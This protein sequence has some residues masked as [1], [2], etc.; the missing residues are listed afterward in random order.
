VLAAPEPTPEDAPRALVWL[1]DDSIL[2]GELG[3]RALAD[4]Y[5]VTVFR[6]GATMLEALSAD[7]K[8]DLLILDWH[9][10]NMAGLELCHFVR[11]T[12]DPGNLPILILTA[13]GGDDLAEAFAAGANDFVRKPYSQAEFDARV[14]ALLRNQRIHARLVEVEQRLRV[15]G[16]FRERFI[17]VLAH[18]L[19]QPLNTFLFAN[20]AIA[21]AVSTSKTA[22]SLL[23]MQSRTAHRMTRMVTEL[24]D[25]TRSRPETGMP[26]ERRPM[27]LEP[28]ARTIIEEMRVG[29]PSHSF[30]LNVRGPC[31]GC[32]DRDRLAQIC[33]NLIGNAIEHSSSPSS[34]IEVGVEERSQHVEL[35]VS[36]EGTPIPSSLLPELF[37]PFRR[38]RDA[39]H[40]NGGL[41][42]GL[43]I[44]QEIVRA[45][46][47]TVS[48]ESN[49]RATVFRV[50]LPI[51]PAS[52]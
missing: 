13:T 3:R 20:H 50:S 1:V 35:A 7:G 31:K 43:Y 5:D 9:M 24:L 52:V 39:T 8:P 47:G 17:G 32:W 29:H 41:G 21:P 49:V 18:D 26:I 46:G 34:P 40:A 15:E 45:H 12:R 11:E 2:Q 23:A 30:R 10:P 27:D 33:S 36:N 14:A 37:E 51:G 38:G 16:E 19:R 25:F 4:A 42:L 28:L 22:V 48:A 6:D 44:V